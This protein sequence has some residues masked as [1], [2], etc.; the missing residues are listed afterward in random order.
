MGDAGA[1][2]SKMA[3]CCISVT[4]SPEYPNS[5]LSRN[6]CEEEVGC[7]ATV[8]SNYIAIW[9]LNVLNLKV[10]PGQHYRST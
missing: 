6:T 4:T 8:A 9:P 2:V 5:L 10:W 7:L 3:I 1:H